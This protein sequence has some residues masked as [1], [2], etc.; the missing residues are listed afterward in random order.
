MIV[1]FFP[2]SEEIP[3][4]DQRVA[5]SASMRYQHQGFELNVP[6]PGRAVD[7]AAVARTIAAFHDTHERLYTFAQPDTPVEIVTLRVEAVGM[8]VP[9][10]L[11]ELPAG[12]PLRRMAPQV[13]WRRRRIAMSWSSC[14]RSLG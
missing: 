1:Y 12:E 9:P 14:S 10:Q 11:E 2:R 7:A 3:A 4:K 8:F 6:W 13:S 5:W